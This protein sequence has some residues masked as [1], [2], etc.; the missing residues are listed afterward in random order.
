MKSNVFNYSRRVNVMSRLTF[1]FFF[2]M[3]FFVAPAQKIK[4]IEQTSIKYRQQLAIDGNLT[5]WGDSL[6]YR[7]EKQQLQYEIAN[8]DKN[9][10]VAMHVKDNSWQMQALHQGFNLIINKDGKK[11]D[12][13]EITFPIP[14]RESLRALAAK[15]ANEK[16]SDARQAVLGTARAIFVKGLVDV[17]DG[18]ISLE[19]NF[20]I[21]AA[22]KIDSNAISYEAVIP[23][24]RLDLG[25]KDEAT[26]AFNVKING[27]TMR[28][29]G[30]GTM[31]M[32]SNRGYGYRDPYG[33]GNQPS[34]KEARKESGQWLLLKLAKPSL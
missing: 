17:V 9:I 19:N 5:E 32:A 25:N 4:S 29:V 14:D 1:S 15:D 23:F 31:P 12:G 33:Y 20:E 27:V 13:A 21:K 16:A 26:L 11:R 22:V 10:Y 18:P 6:T 8:D 3:A 7:Y 2:I 30:G 34:R 28:T 24:E